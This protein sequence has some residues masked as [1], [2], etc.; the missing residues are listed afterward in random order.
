MHLDCTRYTLESRERIP[1]VIGVRRR[2]RIRGNLAKMISCG[3]RAWR[4]TTIMPAGL[5]GPRF[6]GSQPCRLATAPLGC[7][8]LHPRA[9]SQCS[10]PGRPPQAATPPWSGPGWAMPPAAWHRMAPWSPPGGSSCRLVRAV[11]LPASRT[12]RALNVARC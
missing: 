11:M 7:F 9:L 2:R 8:A 5:M 1:V 3:L 4:L 10:V 6:S 12:V